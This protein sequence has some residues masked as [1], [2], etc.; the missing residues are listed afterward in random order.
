MTPYGRKKRGEAFQDCLDQLDGTGQS[1]EAVLAAHP[2]QA[3]ALRPELETARWLVEGRPDLEPRPGFTG[4]SRA[5]L[6]ERLAEDP[7]RTSRSKLHGSFPSLRYP[8]T[9]KRY[10]PRLTLVYLLLLALLFNL[11]QVSKAALNWL[12][13]DLGYPLKL[14]F[15]ETALFFSPTAAGDARLHTEFAHRRLLEAQA[16]VFENRFEQIPPTVANFSRQVDLAVHGVGRVARR[17]RGQ[18]QALALGLERVLSDQELMVKL[19]SGFTPQPERRD[20]Q[21]VLI[22]AEDGVS[23]VQQVIDSGSRGGARLALAWAPAY[24]IVR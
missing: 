3:E 9:W 21:Q 7:R 1:L 20:F 12:P 10:A 2:A 19:L 16:L 18:A 4:A 14:G 8:S 15:E 23:A 17:D 13:G 11:G 5:R 22:I 24:S 6:L